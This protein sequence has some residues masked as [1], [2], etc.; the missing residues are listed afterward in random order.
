MT[1][2]SDNIFAKLILVEGSAPSSPSASDFKLYF[3]SSDHLFK[4]KNSAGTVT[5]YGAG[6]VLA[7]TGTNITAGDYTSKSSTTFA[8]LDATNLKLTVVTGAH[9]VLIGVV[10]ASAITTGTQSICLDVTIDGTR[11]GQTFGL[12]AVDD[13]VN[14]K[15]VNLSF[16]HMTAA[17]TAASHEFRVQYRVTGSNATFY[18][19]T[20]V[21]PF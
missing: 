15:A 19:S 21:T 4:S 10:C 2:A 18:A 17:L 3:D 11:E 8:D 12:I 9:R 7:G 20:T 14:A 16:V 13:T 1:K 5:T 6:G